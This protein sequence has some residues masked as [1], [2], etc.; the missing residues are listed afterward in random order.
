MKSVMQHAFS[1]VPRAEI[2][3]SVFDRSCGYKTTFNSGYLIPFFVDEVLPGDTFKLDHSI[4]ARLS[5]PIVPIM[6]NVFLETFFFFVPNRLVWENWQRFCG[7][8]DNP[9]DS[10]DYLVP[11]LT[12]PEGGFSNQSIF[13]YMGLPTHIGGYKFNSLALRAY[14]LIYNEWFRDENLQDSVTV[15]KGDSDDLS[16]YTLL[17]RG[18]RHDYFTS[19]LPWPQKGEPVEVPLAGTITADT[20][21]SNIDLTSSTVDMR[22]AGGSTLDPRTMAITAAPNQQIY[23]QA[24][25]SGGLGRGTILDSDHKHQI[26]QTALNAIAANLNISGGSPESVIN[27]NDLR[28]AFQ[29]QRMLEKEAR[30]GSRYTEILR[31][32]FGVIS[33][34]GRL[35]RPE[36]LGGSSTR[37]N[38]TPVAQTASTDNTS[39]Q[40]NLAA[41]GYTADSKH[42]FN[43]SFT[44][45]GIIIGLL[46]VRADLTYQQGLERHWSRQTR[47]DYYWPTLAH[48]G[49]QA[50]LNKE[51]YTQGPSALDSDGN[52]EDD[53]VFGYQERY[54]EYRYKNSQITG[55][56]RSN[57]SAS[58]DVWHLSQYFENL[59]VLN[60]EFIV[61][62]PP[63]ARALAVQDEPQ[64]IADCYFSCKCVRPMPVYSVP[65][66]IDHF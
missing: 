53:K 1:M 62:N 35:Q 24:G 28:T 9:E 66:L 22:W 32:F 41:F 50:V 21:G 10:I 61:D 45:H 54:A 8:R 60:S 47:Y 18:K 64:F 31:G 65:G 25:A 57:D 46:N 36:Y 30:S 56:L 20:L 37:I 44:E 7:E 55:K 16:Y 17:R 34:D 63:I 27:V 23:M 42:V 48:L 38:V 12:A 2:Q 3:R 4:L 33:P 39:P 49:E 58:L 40:G 11:Q 14:N 51:I 15:V 43:H 52:V 6:D 19:C 5:T 13:D 29:V 26:D 59:P